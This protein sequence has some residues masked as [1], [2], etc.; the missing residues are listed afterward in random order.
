MQISDAES[1]VMEVLWRT[2][3]RGSDEIIAELAREPGWH[4]STVKTLLNRLVRKGALAVER[5]GRRFLYTP[6]LRR[7]A[8]VAGQSRGLLDRL[9][10]GRLAPLVA[11][12][13]DA[14]A[15]SADDIAEL[16]RLVENLDD[17]H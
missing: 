5:D 14:R 1:V 2:S 7:A 8:W 6:V 10:D 9:F 15:L 11:H 16:K 13:A 3:P 4:A 12:L 17:E